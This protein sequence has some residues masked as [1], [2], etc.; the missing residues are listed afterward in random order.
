MLTRVRQFWKR[1]FYGYVTSKFSTTEKAMGKEV[2]RK[3]E[4]TY[5]PI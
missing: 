5:F 4:K 1:S 3:T 2:S